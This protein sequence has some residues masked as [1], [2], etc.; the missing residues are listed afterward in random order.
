MEAPQSGW[1]SLSFRSLRGPTKVGCQLRESLR[2]KAVGWV[3][4]GFGA[5]A[6]R[7]AAARGSSTSGSRTMWPSWP[8]CS[9]APP[10]AVPRPGGTQPL[11]LVYPVLNDCFAEQ[12]KIRDKFA[13]NSMQSLFGT[14]GRVEVPWV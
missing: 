7:C 1:T 11:N 8:S 14:W 12:L 13:Q 4:G 2:G 6:A 10:R 5:S 9:W 3:G